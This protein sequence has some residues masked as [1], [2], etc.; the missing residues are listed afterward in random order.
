M[1]EVNADALFGMSRIA[2]PY[3]KATKHAGRIV[4]ISS[5]AAHLGFVG[6]KWHLPP[7]FGAITEKEAK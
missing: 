4:N 3:L 1:L 2:H 6:K 5:M 7:V